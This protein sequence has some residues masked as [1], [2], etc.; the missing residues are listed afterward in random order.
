MLKIVK[1][2]NKILRKRS[3]KVK[4]FLS[5]EIQQF[6][7]ELKETMMSED[8]IGL[9]ANQVDKDLRIL[10]VRTDEGPMAFINPVIY[11]KSFA[12]DL[13]EEGC[14]SFPDIFGIIRR[15]KSIRLFYRDEQGRFRHLKAQGL[16]AR[17]LQHEIDHLRGVLFIDKMVKYTNGQD[18]ILKMREQASVDEI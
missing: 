18:L 13:A 15:S 3:R 1:Y 16:L 5:S 2:P 12:R 7:R 4:N 17:V 10:A 14:L 6:I 9:A 8:G 11:Y